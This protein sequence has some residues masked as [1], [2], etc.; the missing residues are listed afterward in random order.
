MAF[1]PAQRPQTVE[2]M[3][4]YLSSTIVAANRA[5]SAL[6]SNGTALAAMVAHLYNY[7]DVS[8]TEAAG[9]GN[10]V[11]RA[12]QRADTALTTLMVEI[13]TARQKTDAAIAAFHD[14]ETRQRAARV[15]IG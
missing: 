9:K 10:E 1:D 12:A 7:M 2:E 3:R 6:T 5:R 4:E 14:Y 15:R 11:L 13:T 8:D